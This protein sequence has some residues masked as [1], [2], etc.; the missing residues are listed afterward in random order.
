MKYNKKIDCP[1]CNNYKSM[2]INVADDRAKCLECGVDKKLAEV[3]CVEQDD[4]LRE[5]A[6][7]VELM[8][9]NKLY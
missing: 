8:G 5:H 9:Q 1:Y 6:D 3:E 2:L 4:F 7:I